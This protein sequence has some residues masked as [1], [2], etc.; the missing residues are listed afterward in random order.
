MIKYIVHITLLFL[1]SFVPI[2]SGAKA[3]SPILWNIAKLQSLTPDSADYKEIVRKADSFLGKPSIVVTNKVSSLSSDI[4]NYESL[5]TYFWEDE[6]NPE[7]PYIYK[8]GEKNPER[9]DY[10]GAKINDFSYRTKY[11]AQAYFLTGDNRYSAQWLADV[12][13]WFIDKSTFMNPNFEYAQV[14]K[15]TQDNHGNYYGIIDAYVL[16]DV[17]E[18]VLL[19]KELKACNKKTYRKIKYWF[20]DFSTWMRE[21]GNGIKQ[22]QASNNLSVAYDVMMCEFYY[23][24]GDK[25]RYEQIVGQFLSDRLEKQFLPDGTQPHEL[26]RAKPISYSIYN[27]E[28]VLDFCT[29]QWHS[30]VDYYSQNRQ[31]IDAAMDYVANAVLQVDNLNNAEKPDLPV[32]KKKYNA[33]LTGFANIR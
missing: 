9:L 17:V 24:I 27:L 15:N 23:Y 13:A 30:G 2:I 3:L 14:V 1:L 4:H 18:S 5:S 22:S 8:D 32:L 31:L 19:M 21:S 29:M 11:L 26:K 7:G 6:S 10:D 12:H 28:L 20:E 33:L 16:I 25:K